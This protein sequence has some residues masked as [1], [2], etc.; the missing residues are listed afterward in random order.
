MDFAY[1]AEDEAFRAELTEWLDENLEKF[2]AE[3]PHEGDGG[4]DAAGP[5]SGGIIAAMERRR[6]WQ[7]KLNEGRW[8]AISWPEEWGGRAATVTQNVVY[9]ETMARYR[10]P[11]I[12]NANGLWQIGPMIIR[13]GTDEQ[14]Q[15][16]IPNILNA[17]DHWCQGFS[18]PQAGSDLAN[19]RTLAIRD[20]DDYV[21][22][23]QKIWIS[24]AH[25]A[26]WGL[27][28]V[29]TDPA[30][31]AE[32]RK[33]EGI[34][35]LIIDMEAPGIDVRPIR[36]IAGEEMFCEVFFD[37]ARVPVDYRLG[38]EGEGWLVAMGT[39]GSERVGTA[40]LAIGM[41]AD[42]D[43]MINLAKAVNPAALDDPEIRQRIARAHTDIEYTKLLNYRA[44][45][46]ILRNEKNW[47]EVPLAKLQWSHLAQTLAEL[48]V[49][50]LGPYGMMAK[51]APDAVDGGAWNRLYV[52]QRY[53]SIGAGTTE[54]Q[55][56]IIADKAIKLPRK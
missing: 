55:K 56:N 36:D 2:L 17:D 9:S 31:I 50:L 26:K 40:G 19:L 8:A 6:A 14:K 13:W 51:G 33:H 30:A 16:W 15:R 54:V 43:A 22:N 52:F 35:A 47:P 27:F 34:T 53:T 41:R 32:G 29:R 42:L 7:R 11:G 44:L 49:D 46:K 23:G 38:G 12:Y 5:G 10:T 48:A 20:G 28:L 4:D 24:S 45:S 3:H 37:N 21:L 18:E 39:L 25:I 1:T